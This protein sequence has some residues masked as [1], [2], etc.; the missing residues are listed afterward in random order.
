MT[1]LAGKVALITGAA[2]GIGEGIAGAFYR[3][4]AR[5]VLTD[6]QDELGQAKADELGERADYSR[7]DVRLEPDWERVVSTASGMIVANRKGIWESR[8]RPEM[9][10]TLSR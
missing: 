10:S 8:L 5:V 1:R 2:R 7:L 4:G 9:S 6:I 3:E